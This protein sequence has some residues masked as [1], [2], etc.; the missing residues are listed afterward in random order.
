MACVKNGRQI[1]LLVLPNDEICSSAL[2][3]SVRRAS[4]SL[5][6]AH[7]NLIMS[8]GH[9][10]LSVPDVCRQHQPSNPIRQK[11]TSPLYSWSTQL[12]FSWITTQ[13]SHSNSSIS[14]AKTSTL[15]QG[16]VG[17]HKT[18]NLK[19][20]VKITWEEMRSNWGKVQGKIWL[21]GILN[22]ILYYI[23]ALLHNTWFT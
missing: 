2:I 23:T 17:T 5:G 8:A 14:E 20:T 13:I 16:H 12:D 19:T 22:T 18:A 1:K 21:K 6:K 10:L 7:L 3:L 15:Q 11:Q 9:A 4:L